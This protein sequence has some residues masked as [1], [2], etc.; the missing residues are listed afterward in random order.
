MELEQ[1]IRQ[2]YRIPIT[3]SDEISVTINGKKHE[4]VNL[5]SHGIGVRVANPVTFEV[6]NQKHDIELWLVRDRL[7]LKGKIVHVTSHGPDHYLCGIIFSD[8][9]ETSQEKL[10][11][12]LYHIRAGLF[13]KE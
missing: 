3:E 7:R 8:L 4:V 10:L 11:A 9:D 13:G 6:D 1:I 12:C 5:G 2:I